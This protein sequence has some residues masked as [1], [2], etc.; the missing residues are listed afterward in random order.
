MI[1]TPRARGKQRGWPACPGI[2]P[3]WAGCHPRTHRSTISRTSKP[4]SRG[5]NSVSRIV[6]I[7]LSG[8]SPLTRGKLRRL[9]VRDCLQRLIPAHA[10]KTTHTAPRPC[11]PWAHPHSHGEN[12]WE[13]C[14]RALEHGSSLLTQGNPTP[15]FFGRFSPRLIPTHAGKTPSHSIAWARRSAHPRS[16][17]ENASLGNGTPLATGSSPLTR[18]K[19]VTKPIT[20]RL[21]G[22]IPAHAGKTVCRLMSRAS[23][24]AHPRSRG[25]NRA[26][27]SS[28]WRVH[29]S[30][31]LT[32]GKPDVAVVLLEAVRLIP[33]HT[34]NTW[35]S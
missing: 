18:G 17:G 21:L 34:G 24:W 23:R 10:G 5:E 33:A 9:R 13:D 16:H 12:L 29:G 28:D 26:L 35:P 14:I 20:G 25:E 31:P 15:V 19:L 8:S 6:A 3:R 1:S 7:A 22:L 4:R 2:T 27:Q 11:S 32:R 30:S